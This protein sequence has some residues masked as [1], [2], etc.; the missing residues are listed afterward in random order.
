MLAFWLLCV[1]TTNAEPIQHY[2]DPA[3]ANG[4]VLDLDLWVSK[5]DVQLDGTYQVWWEK[6][7]PD[8]V[9]L[10]CSGVVQVNGGTPASFPVVDIESGSATGSIP[11][12][13]SAGDIV[14]VLVDS[15]GVVDEWNESNNWLEFTIPGVSNPCSPYPVS[16]DITDPADPDGPKMT[17]E[18]TKKWSYRTG[19]WPYALLIVPPYQYDEESQEAIYGGSMQTRLRRETFEGDETEDAVGLTASI[20]IEAEFGPSEDFQV[21]IGAEIKQ[22]VESAVGTGVET[23]WAEEYVAQAYAGAG[24]EHTVVLIQT[25]YDVCEYL[26][27]SGSEEGDSIWVMPP[28]PLPA[29]VSGYVMNPE[30]TPQALGWYNVLKD[31]DAVGLNDA[32]EMGDKS[33]YEESY[34]DIDLTWHIVNSTIQHQYLLVRM[35][36]QIGTAQAIWEQSIREYS[37]ST[38]TQFTEH[39]AYAKGEFGG[40]NVEVSFGSSERWSHRTWAGTA[41]HFHWEVGGVAHPDYSYT[42]GA[43]AISAIFDHGTRLDDSLLLMCYDLPEPSAPLLVVAGA[44]VLVGLRR[45]S[46]RG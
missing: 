24:G 21:T 9:P 29:Y 18:C 13:I 34:S 11:I 6:R 31:P 3:A 33:T 41:T 26:V 16:M 44:G 17:I 36:N 27:T 42:V 10:G 22:G 32:H 46:R 2:S 7:G 12:P 40:T 5:L 19:N 38:E 25:V 8:T 4:A 43:F 15:G 20:A 37:G 39:N 28:Q 45:V 14:T 1:A 30:L 35:V 23:S